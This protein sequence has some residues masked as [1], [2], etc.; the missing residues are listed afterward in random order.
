[1]KRAIFGLG[2]VVFMFAG[3]S[4]ANA[5]ILDFSDVDFFF[6]STSIRNN[7]GNTAASVSWDESA[8]YY[9]EPYYKKNVDIYEAN[10][11]DA[12]ANSKNKKRFLKR[13]FDNWFKGYN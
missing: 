6:M 1:M 3:I 7:F 11:V 4:F 13:V 2:L 8:Y 12:E 5:Y 9:E 10:Y